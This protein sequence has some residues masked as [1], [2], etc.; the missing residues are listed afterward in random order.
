M[1]AFATELGRMPGRVLALALD[2]ASQTYWLYSLIT[3]VLAIGIVWWR[4]VAKTGNRR[5]DPRHVLRTLFSPGVWLHPSAIV[6]YWCYAINAI[7]SSILRVVGFMAGLV[8]SLSSYALLLKMSGGQPLS[9]APGLVGLA[10]YT[11]G[12]LMLVDLGKYVGHYLQHR[13]PLLWEF[14]KVHHSAQVLTPVT[15]FRVHPV[16]LAFYDFI[17]G[18]FLG[19]SSAA[20]LFMFGSEIEPVTVLGLNV[21]LFLFYAL[22]ANLRHSH[23]WLP[24]PGWLS[25]ILISPAQH[26]I[27]HSSL[28]QHHDANFGVLFALWDWMFGTLYVPKEHEHLVFGL[29]DGED[30]EYQ[31]VGGLYAVPFKKVWA[32]W[33][34]TRGAP[35]EQPG[36]T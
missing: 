12:S 1:E 17:N 15:V 24:Y 22:G 32:R 8:A 2:P 27:H 4:A 3:L 14:H 6:D 28:R 13:V 18:I 23:I 5:F 11:L 16:D 35:V 19:A 33:F 25:R 9:L 26:Q 10:V 34:G 7:L 20:G 21:G 36:A 29:Q 30:H 31:S